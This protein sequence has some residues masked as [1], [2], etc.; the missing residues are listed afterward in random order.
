MQIDTKR[1][2][3]YVGFKLPTILLDL[4]FKFVII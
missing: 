3:Y 4:E 1:F 2:Y